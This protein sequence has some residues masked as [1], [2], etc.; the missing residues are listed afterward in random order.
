M[1]ER[2]S[3]AELFAEFL[4]VAPPKTTPAPVPTKMDA[5]RRNNP[6]HIAWWMTA[7]GGVVIQQKGTR[8]FYGVCKACGTSVQISR[9]VSHRGRKGGPTNTGR[10][11]DYCAACRR[12]RDDENAGTK[13][14]GY[15]R[16]QRA[17]EKAVRDARRAAQGLPPIRQGVPTGFERKPVDYEPPTPTEG[18]A[19]VDPMAAHLDDPPAGWPTAKPWWPV[20]NPHRDESIDQLERE[21]LLARKRH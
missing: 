5:W 17:K 20:G 18:E 16:R 19:T 8:T 2:P 3:I 1:N 15:K 11:P 14:R 4:G 6:D 10:W 12:H 7:N 13:A 21:I 9:D